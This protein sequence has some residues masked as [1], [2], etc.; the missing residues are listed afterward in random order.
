MS[1]MD[2][3]LFTDGRGV[4]RCWWCAASPEYI[5]YHDEEWGFPVTDDVRLF[6]KVCLEGFQAGLSWLTI[7]RKREAFRE[8][9]RGF[10]IERVAQFG[11]KDIARLLGMLGSYGIEERSNRPSTTRGAHSL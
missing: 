6:E 4:R 3:R 10:E 9:F 7:L 1:V 11:Q 8:A 5:R 2:D